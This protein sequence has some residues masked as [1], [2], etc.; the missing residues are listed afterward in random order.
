MLIFKKMPFIITSNDKSVHQLIFEI[1]LIFI[2][3]AFIHGCEVKR[4]H[5][6]LELSEILTLTVPKL[7]F[8][9]INK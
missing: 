8:K 4:H 7:C 6:E 1:K 5:F 9:F 3:Q 2:V